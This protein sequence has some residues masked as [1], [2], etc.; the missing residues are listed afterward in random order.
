M[1]DIF[2]SYARKDE[3]FVR[4]LFDA[5]EAEDRAVWVD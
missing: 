3:A 1:A 2:I 5:L 4:R